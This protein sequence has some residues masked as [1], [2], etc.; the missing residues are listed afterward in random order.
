MFV[1]DIDWTLTTSKY[2]FNP[3]GKEAINKEVVSTLNRLSGQGNRVI[4]LTGRASKYRKLTEDWLK[5]HGIRHDALYMNDDIHTQ[6]T[7][8]KKNQIKRL[9]T[10]GRKIQGWYDNNPSVGKVAEELRIPFTLIR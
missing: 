3:T 4:I 1:F 6:S 8:Y 7:A 5:S 10:P 2:G 9:M